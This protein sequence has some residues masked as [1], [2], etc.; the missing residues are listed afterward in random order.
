MTEL[1]AT[2]KSNGFLYLLC[3]ASYC[4]KLASEES[5]SFKNNRLSRSSIMA[6]ALSI[7]SCANVLISQLK[8]SK[9]YSNEL[10]KLSPLGKIESFLRFKKFN[11]IDRGANIWQ[12]IQEIIQI[13]NSHVHPK[14]MNID[15]SILPMIKHEEH[16][17]IPLHIFNE[18]WPMIKIPK[19]SIFWSH[20]AANK[21]L[22][23]VISFYN[24]LFSKLINIP[25]K[26]VRLILFDYIYFGEI[27][28][29]F[30]YEEVEKELRRL[31]SDGFKLDFLFGDD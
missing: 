6:S 22:S 27:E 26:E 7:E 19:S 16:M 5:D 21:V 29:P 24:T 9:S 3:D 25:P 30:N 1:P 15:G 12:K 23:T 8:Y 11:A 14:L 20:D 28:M 18:S 13:R 2:Y 31:Y 4:L 17:E 10:D